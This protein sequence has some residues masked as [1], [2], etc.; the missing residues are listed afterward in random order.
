MPGLRPHAKW[1]LTLGL[2]AG[3][4]LA[5]QSS[6]PSFENGQVIV[7][8][9]HPGVDV[10]GSAHKMH[11]HKLNRVMV[12]FHDGGELLHYLDGRTV[13]LKWRAG[14][15]RWSPA[16]GFH[17]SE[18]P[19]WLDPRVW[20]TP[21]FSGPM[22]LDIGIKKPG[23]PA[24]AAGAA[25]DPLRVDR[26]DYKLEF[27]NGQVR[28]TRVRMGPRQTVPMHEH[29]LSRVIVYITDASVRETSPDGKAAVIE[30]RAGDFSWE[31]PSKHKGENLSGQPFE[32]VVV[33]LKTA[34]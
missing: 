19:S 28:V 1:A 5:A 15:V 14:D 27:E 7:N 8:A 3:A 32:A 13:D 2:L 26:Q 33:E 18:I 12:Y 22:G 34:D 9:P 17:Y 10:P 11:D 25:L 30:H 6:Q 23:D 16:S 4:R 21:A 20:K 24:K 29:P 31:V